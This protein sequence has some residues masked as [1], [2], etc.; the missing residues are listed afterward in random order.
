[1][2]REAAVVRVTAEDAQGN[3]E[4]SCE[5]RV[6]E[7][8]AGGNADTVENRLICRGMLKVSELTEEDVQ[9]TRQ[10]LARMMLPLANTAKPGDDESALQMAIA[11]KL[12]LIHI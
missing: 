7:T 5:Y 12:S 3:A 4:T 10:Q 2:P 11:N 8:A 1:M 9:I 6:L